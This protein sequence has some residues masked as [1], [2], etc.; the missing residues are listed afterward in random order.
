MKPTNKALLSLSTPQIPLVQSYEGETAP[1]AVPEITAPTVQPIA[2]TLADTPLSSPAS[3]TA[4]TPAPQPNLVVPVSQPL[5]TR[6]SN[7]MVG[8]LI[9]TGLALV[10]VASLVF[11]ARLHLASLPLV[12]PLAEIGVAAIDQPEPA[13]AMDLA[14]PLRETAIPP[15]VAPP[16]QNPAKLKIG[17]YQ[18]ADNVEKWRRWARQQNVTFEV[19][20]K[21]R[22]GEPH[23][24]LYL[25]EPDPARVDALIREV[26]RISGETPLLVR[27]RQC[28]HLGVR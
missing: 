25:Y 13:Y 22:N 11:I 21:S 8:A 14:F 26:A 2:P 16:C 24:V 17:V 15:P 1:H 20:K 7:K 3:V 6:A 5:P 4:A 10:L 28:Q 18:Q 19:V 27:N 12:E 23:Y 9:C